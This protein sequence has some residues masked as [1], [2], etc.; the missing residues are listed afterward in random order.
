M[1]RV[2][3]MLVVLVVALAATIGSAEAVGPP[4][5][6]SGTFMGAVPGNLVVP[7]G[8]ACTILGAMI[9]GDVLVEPGAVGFHSDHSTIDGSVHAPGPIVS[10]VRLVDSAVGNN[11]RVAQTQQGTSI[12]ICT[13]TIGGTVNLDHN[14]GL[15]IVGLDFPVCPFPGG[16]NHIEGNLI[17]AHN[18][19]GIGI[20]FNTVDKSV[21]V[22]NNTNFQEI[23]NNEIAL[24]LE[25]A[26]N[27]PPP[28]PFSVGNTAKVFVGQCTG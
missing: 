15:I 9:G 17:V 6:C 25:C 27:T 16:R 2:A 10:D 8:E 5:E 1:R 12:G 28:W 19:G 21:H 24:T 22:N 13:S 23:V 20:S 14:A 26:N 4:T 3:P 11:V 7:S 18:S